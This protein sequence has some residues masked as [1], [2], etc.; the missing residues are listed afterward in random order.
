[1]ARTAGILAD[2]TVLRVQF[3]QSNAI[4]QGFFYFILPILDLSAGLELDNF[5]FQKYNIFEE[6]LFF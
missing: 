4:V 1:M 3:Q 6:T 5:F 2:P